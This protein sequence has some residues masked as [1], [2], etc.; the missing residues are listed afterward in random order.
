MFAGDMLFYGQWGSGADALSGTYDAVERRDPQQLVVGGLM[1]IIGGLGYSLGAL[2]VYGRLAERPSWLRL[3]V[4][5]G[6]LATAVIATATHAVWG[7]FALT[8][9]SGAPAPTL[10]ANYLAL[11]FA[12][13]VVVGIPVSFLLA[14]SI[15]LGRTDW[16]IWF[17]AVNPGAIYLL[18]STA[19]Y[20]PAPFGASFVGGAFNLAFAAFYGIII[21]LQASRSAS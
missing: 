14:G 13:G 17:A 10:I 11:H 7:S 1:S 9:V 21:A 18:L 2:H 5:A 19:S 15:A 12:I 3:S 20:L 4:T 6:L 8:V 16:P